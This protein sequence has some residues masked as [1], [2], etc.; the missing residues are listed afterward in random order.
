MKRE[1]IPE[2]PVPER[3]IEALDWLEQAAVLIESAD[4]EQP[5]IRVNRAFTRLTGYPAEEVLGRDLSF[6]Q[7]RF[8][9]QQPQPHQRIRRAISGGERLRLVLRN[10]RRDGTSFWSELSLCPVADS[11]GGN[12]SG[13]ISMLRD[14]TE[15]LGERAARVQPAGLPTRQHFLELLERRWREA[16]RDIKPLTIYLMDL[17][18]F[19]PL[20]ERLDPGTS[21][22]LL[23][24]LAARLRSQFRRASDTIAHDEAGRFAA[25][26]LGLTPAQAMHVAQNAANAIRELELGA[27]DQPVR[28]T[29]STGM[30]TGIP[31]PVTE[32]SRV[33][34]EAEEALLEARQAGGDM[35][36][37]HEY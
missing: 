31:T 30:S 7:G 1:S 26:S 36:R 14:V 20:S 4:P 3:L 29:L 6:L 12:G 34:D 2:G 10:E 27:G 8:L 16:M 15:L 23:A 33:L 18:G 25:I 32:L 9:G 22:R 35:L 24:R 11:N 17:D 19:L 21:A 13:C 5:I 28:F 37:L